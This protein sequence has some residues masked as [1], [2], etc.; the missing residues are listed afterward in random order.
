MIERVEQLR[1]SEAQLA[2]RLSSRREPN[3]TDREAMR[4]ITDAPDDVPATPGGLAAH[5]GVSTAAITSVLRRLQERG[6]I[7]VAP[8]PAD[9]RSKVVRPTLR[10]LHAP[11]DDMTRRMEGL[12]SE[13]TPEQTEVVLRFLRRLTEE[14]D[15]LP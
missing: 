14:L 7:L 12:A 15:D 4:F 10:D 3:D 8:H 6:Q 2:R 1:R 5:L 9:A 13:F 11:S